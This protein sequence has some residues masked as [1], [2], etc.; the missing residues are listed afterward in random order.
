MGTTDNTYAVLSYLTKTFGMAE[1]DLRGQ[2]E[3]PEEMDYIE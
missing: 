3:I 1:S 2:F